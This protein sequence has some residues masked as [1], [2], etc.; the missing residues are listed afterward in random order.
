LK[1]DGSAGEPFP[2][3]VSSEGTLPTRGM[4][5]GQAFTALC[6]ANQMVVGFEGRAGSF[7]DQFVVVCAPLTAASFPFLSVARGTFSKLTAVGGTGGD[8]FQNGCPA[9][10]IAVGY[11]GEAVTVVDTLA[12]ACAVPSAV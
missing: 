3:T 10:A 8:V 7:I 5:Q 4:P 2:V 12:L 9:G 11:R 1:V 6:P